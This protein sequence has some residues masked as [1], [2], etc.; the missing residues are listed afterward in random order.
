[1]L[2]ESAPLAYSPWDT[3]DQGGDRVPAVRL[4]DRNV[5]I[6][7]VF[8]FAVVLAVINW[9]L[10][11]CIVMPLSRRVMRHPSQRT[12]K[13]QRGHESKVVK[14]SLCVMEMLF[15]FTF[16][17]LNYII[18]CREAWAWPSKLWWLDFE[19]RDLATGASLH[20]FMTEVPYLFRPIEK[21]KAIECFSSLAM[22]FWPCVASRSLFPAVCRAISSRRRVR[23][24]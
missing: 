16:A 5:D 18:L 3:V 14:L 22:I 23:A 2:S 9:G 24:V 8:F 15:Y 13:Q 6:I 1:V 12:L 7:V 20:S 17:C 4:P 11:L 10:R 21:D 19:K